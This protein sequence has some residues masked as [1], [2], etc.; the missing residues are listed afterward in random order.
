MKAK[1]A[2]PNRL[3]RVCPPSLHS[4]VAASSLAWISLGAGKVNRF[5]GCELLL[6]DCTCQQISLPNEATN[7]VYYEV[8]DH[9]C[10]HMLIDFWLQRNQ[11][12][13]GT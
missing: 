9:V 3:W 1:C 8:F 5:C 11:F 13:S 7:A 2:N 6:V 4:R 10:F 12:A